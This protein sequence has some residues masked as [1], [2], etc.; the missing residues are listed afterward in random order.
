MPFRLFESRI[1]SRLVNADAHQRAVV[2]EAPGIGPFPQLLD[3]V[4]EGPV[5][6]RGA[7]AQVDELL[8]GPV[9]AV[10]SKSKAPSL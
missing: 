5:C 7:G 4:F 8:E 9:P 3:E 6:A 10:G 1:A 2:V